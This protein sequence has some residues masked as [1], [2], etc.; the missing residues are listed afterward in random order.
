MLVFDVLRINVGCIFIFFFVVIYVRHML[1]VTVP[2]VPGVLTLSKTIYKN[3]VSALQILRVVY[4][5][6]HTE[7][8]Y[9]AKCRF[10]T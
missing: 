3:S 2:C 8:Q 6:N 1:P 9:V 5:E 7:M 10:L 4:S